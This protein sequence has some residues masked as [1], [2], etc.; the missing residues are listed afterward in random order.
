[1]VC[2]LYWY[3]VKGKKNPCE[4][5]KA[6]KHA[7]L[8]YTMSFTFVGLVL[9]PE[10]ILVRGLV[11]L[12]PAVAYHFC[13]NLPATFSQPSTSIISGPSICVSHTEMRKMRE[14]GCVNQACTRA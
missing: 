1:M 11:K 10:K 7:L 2:M 14:L 13:L 4:M 8:L 9:G 3:I 6:N 12:D 5:V